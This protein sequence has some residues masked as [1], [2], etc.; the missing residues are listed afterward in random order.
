MTPGSAADQVA[1]R[2]ADA[3]G[4][5][6]EEIKLLGIAAAIAVAGAVVLRTLQWLVD[7]GFDRSAR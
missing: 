5:S 6:K 1:V 4:R 2:L 3:T 7:L